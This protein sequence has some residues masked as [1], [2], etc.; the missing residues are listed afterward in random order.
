MMKLKLINNP[1]PLDL[2]R[3]QIGAEQFQPQAKP[4]RKLKKWQRRYVQVPWSWV[5]RLQSAKRVSTYRLALLLLYEAWKNGDK[6]LALSN[7]LA[8]EVGLSR[9]AKWLGL[10]ELEKV[11]LVRI[12]RHK[13]RAPR[14]IIPKHLSTSVAGTV[15]ER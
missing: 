12:E 11:G 2:S 6:P 10:R 5:E 15:N 13:G 1:N 4:R 7:V 14:L 9:Q 3:L 8:A